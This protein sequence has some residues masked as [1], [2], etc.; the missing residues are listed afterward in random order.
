METVGE[1][2]TFYPKSFKLKQS[3]ASVPKSLGQQ[4]LRKFD[5]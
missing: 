2:P 4:G 5:L 3:I 1:P